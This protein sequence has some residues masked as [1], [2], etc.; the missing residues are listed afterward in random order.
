VVRYTVWAREYPPGAQA[1]SGGIYEQCNVFGS[2]TGVRVALASAQNLP[3]APRGF[4]GRVVEPPPEAGASH[5]EIGLAAR[6]AE[7]D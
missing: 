3:A 4:T 1:P 6:S 7:T 5:R 2:T